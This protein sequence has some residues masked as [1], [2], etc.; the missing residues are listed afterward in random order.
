MSGC[1]AYP[2]T[3]MLARLLGAL[4]VALV[5]TPAA[6]A[7]VITNGSFESPVTPNGGFTPFPTGSMGI[8]GWT[9]GG[10]GDVD[11]INTNYNEGG[12]T[13]RFNAQNGLNSVDL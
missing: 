3:P 6:S 11:L 13:V 9:V 2:E 5:L 1:S 12:G 4:A 10:P 8:T 7:A